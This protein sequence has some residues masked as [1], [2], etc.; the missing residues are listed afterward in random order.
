MSVLTLNQVVARRS[1]SSGSQAD[2]SCAITGLD[3]GVAGQEGPEVRHCGD[4][5]LA[6][7]SCPESVLGL[8]SIA[9]DRLTGGVMK[10]FLASILLAMMFAAGSASAG[11]ATSQGGNAEGGG[12]S[13]TKSNWDT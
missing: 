10:A 7:I 5:S 9:F 4:A 1:I 11:S 12:C 3:A 8:F 2:A 13:H 6:G